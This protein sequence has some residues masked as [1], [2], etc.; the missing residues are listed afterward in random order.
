MTT[1][2]T[3]TATATQ[4]TTTEGATT[5]PAPQGGQ[6]TAADTLDALLKEF[7]QPATPDPKQGGD[8]PAGSATGVT[9]E[10]LE[11]VVDFV[12]AAA[13]RDQKA[14][15]DKAVSDSITALKTEP[16]LKHLDDEAVRLLLLGKGNSDSRFA[17][18]FAQRHQKPAEWGKVLKA[19]AGET[20]AKFRSHPDAKLTSDREALLAATRGQGTTQAPQQANWGDLQK[21]SDAQFKAYTESLGA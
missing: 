19:F 4:G 9:K 18:A 16:E 6:A 10:K 11:R 8:K 20:A 12:E 7:E 21:M 5:Q 1:E 13:Q 14:D 2:Q 15:F 3:A 17:M